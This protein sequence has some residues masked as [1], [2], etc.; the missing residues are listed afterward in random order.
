M[1][2]QDIK[3]SIIIPTYNREKL[4][5]LSTLSALHQDFMEPFE[6]IVVDDGSQDET[7]NIIN[8][9]KESYRNLV[10]IRQSN[11]GPSAARNQGFAV[12]K[13]EFIQFLDSDDLLHPRKIALQVDALRKAQY[14]ALATCV[15]CGFRKKPDE[16]GPVLT[17]DLKRHSTILP[18]FFHRHLWLT[19][20]ALYRKSAVE[21]VGP[22]NSSLRCFE[23]WEWHI[24]MGLHGFRFVHV[25]ETLAFVRM[26]SG[27]RLSRFFDVRR[28]QM[29][30]EYEKYLDALSSQFL[31]FEGAEDRYGSD[32]ASLYFRTA[33]WNFR[34]GFS[35][36]AQSCIK[37]ALR[38]RISPVR[39]IIYKITTYFVLMIGP[40]R[41]I[42]YWDKISC[43]LVR[44]V[45]MLFWGR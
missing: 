21:V 7:P 1:Q 11:L 20:T 28:R 17:A 38:I 34:A 32:L 26:H 31:Q 45:R 39:L 4:V 42:N 44:K 25:P 27:E 13:G 14:A 15:T 37:K 43:G 41:A 24:R 23:D 35:D 12:A 33:F 8:G 2:I 9:L 3:V 10:Y 18:E 6:V 16:G 19:P 5:R 30:A 29:L 22:W 40:V 36:R